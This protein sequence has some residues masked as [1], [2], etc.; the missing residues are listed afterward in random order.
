MSWYK[1]NQILKKSSNYTST[2]FLD[3]WVQDA[4]WQNKCFWF[5]WAWKR[6]SSK[7]ISIDLRKDVMNQP[8]PRYILSQD[9]GTKIRLEGWCFFCFD[10]IREPPLKRQKCLGCHEEHLHRECFRILS[11]K[12][13]SHCWWTS[14][15]KSII[16][17][18]DSFLKLMGK[19][20]QMY[21]QNLTSSMMFWSLP[22]LW[23]PLVVFEND[24]IS[25]KCPRRV[26]F[27]NCSIGQSHFSPT[28]FFRGGVG[29]VW[30]F[31]APQIPIKIVNL[32]REPT[33]CHL[34]SPLFCRLPSTNEKQN[35]DAT[36]T[37]LRDMMG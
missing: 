15:L 18:S 33:K 21:T 13:L 8:L 19:D 26:V 14:I 28:I 27:W 37:S 23:R 30:K 16:L 22:S 2:F 9:R 20:I 11:S 25:G 17:T 34:L 32:S 36:L 29:Y 3:V 24:V 1:N 6:I 4:S 31:W 12:H 35:T 10:L 5:W 7:Q